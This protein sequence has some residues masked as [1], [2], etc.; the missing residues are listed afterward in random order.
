MQPASPAPPAPPA[1]PV[2]VA[3]IAPKDIRPGR[4]W[5]AT[6]AAVAL[7]LT[8][9]SVVLGMNAVSGVADAVDDGDQFANG[10]T[11]T[12]RLG[13]DSDKSVWISDPGPGF[14]STC[15]ITGPGDP[16]LTAPGI[17]VFLTYDQTWNPRYAI[18]VTRTGDY[19]LT[20]QAPEPAR[21]ALGKSG[22]FFSLAGRL[23]TAVL[24]A[25]FGLVA[26]VVIVVVTA[27]RRRGHRERLLAERHAAA[28]AG[29]PAHPG[30]AS[31]GR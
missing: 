19:A 10:E 12:V 7:V 25:G 5:Y 27:L 18:E 3:S 2:P 14:D 20:C 13:P 1:P 9:L 16:K 24:L 29:R 11:V 23:M 31:G 4:H 26:C 28:A 21:Y 17:D 22:G 30:P 15:V 6:A 8:V